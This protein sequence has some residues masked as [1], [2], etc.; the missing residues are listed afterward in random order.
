MIANFLVICDDYNNIKMPITPV[1]GVFAIFG[2][3]FDGVSVLDS[4]FDTTKLSQLVSKTTILT[5]SFG[6]EDALVKVKAAVDA[7]ISPQNYTRTQYGYWAQ[8]GGQ[9]CYILNADFG[10]G[11]VD[12]LQ[13]SSEDFLQPDL[14][15]INIKLFSYDL[16]Q[17]L[18]TIARDV[19]VG[20]VN[21]AYHF[22]K[23][24]ILLHFDSTDTEILSNIEQK[25]YQH[26]GDKI[27][28]ES[29][30]DLVDA[31][32]E[33][34]RVQRRRLL[35][36]DYTPSRLF[37]G[38]LGEQGCGQI[39]FLHN[40]DF[41]NLDKARD[42]IHSQNFDILTII[43]QNS[44]GL[45]LAFIDETKCKN[46]LLPFKSFQKYGQKGAFYLILYKI[47]EKFRKNTW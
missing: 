40:R 19:L 2:L 26:F 35:V 29:S 11:I 4:S 41:K 10:Q 6:D 20:N 27:Y 39:E 45:I 16:Q 3:N 15:S 43:T 33:L 42:Y 9:S 24:D 23:G 13:A 25:L 5:V 22:D 18:D 44:E 17:I 7:A 8:A 38:Q 37:E 28:I 47:F 31:I 46:A 30:S 34:L 1:M 36:Q 32:L 14:E 12:K 21:F